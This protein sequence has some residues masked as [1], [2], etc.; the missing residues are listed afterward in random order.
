VLGASRLNGLPIPAVETALAG[1][2]GL[3]ISGTDLGPGGWR[4]PVAGP[5]PPAGRR[6]RRPGPCVTMPLAGPVRLLSGTIE[7]H[8]REAPTSRAICQWGSM[9]PFWRLLVLVAEIWLVSWIPQGLGHRT[10]RPMPCPSGLQT[11]LFGGV[12]LMLVSSGSTRSAKVLALRLASRARRRAAE[13]ARAPRAKARLLA[14]RRS[15]LRP[16]SPLQAAVRAAAR[17]SHSQ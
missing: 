1:A 17:A 16:Q 2:G 15:S 6:G 9:P 3:G 12:A 10:A 7:H 11:L 5:G 4:L 13:R 8:D 14:V